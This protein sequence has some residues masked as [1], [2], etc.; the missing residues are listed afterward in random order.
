MHGLQ[1]A[2]FLDRDGVINRNIWNPDTGAFEAP[3]SASQFIL[4]PG[5][6]DAL[7]C[8]A[9]AGYLLFLVS[10]QPN[11]A[12]GKAGLNDPA[13]IHRT[14]L[15]RMQRADISFTGCF[16][17][18]HHPDG[19]IRDYTGCCLCRKPSPYFLRM[20]SRSF[21]VDLPGSWMIGDRATDIVC[22]QA[23]GTHTAW[24]GEAWPEAPRADIRA[25]DL[26]EAAQ[27]ILYRDTAPGYGAAGRGKGERRLPSARTSTSDS[28]LR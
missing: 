21:D 9:R 3:L 2:I 8:L 4:I 11:Y 18:F 22:G 26:R 6:I 20:A 14:F 16:Y 25:R 28:P 19:R 7:R 13:A 5:V 24:V 10:N 1:R 17:C 15:K 12:K 23:A 27:I